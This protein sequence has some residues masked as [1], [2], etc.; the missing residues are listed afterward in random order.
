MF[1]LG[2]SNNR[3]EALN[4]D[5]VDSND[6]VADDID[7]EQDVVDD[8]NETEQLEFS[9]QKPRL[10][11]LE[12]AP[13]VRSLMATKQENLDKVKAKAEELESL[14]LA[15]L[16]GDLVRNGHIDKGIVEPDFLEV[17]QYSFASSTLLAA[18]YSTSISFIPNQSAFVR[19]H[20]ITNNTMLAHELMRGKGIRQGDP[21]SLYLFVL[22]M[23]VL[24][25]L[26]D[27]AAIN[28]LFKY[29]LKC[30]RVRLTHL[31]FADDLLIF[32]KGTTDS[33]AGVYC[34]L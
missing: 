1:V 3:F 21:P 34:V 31:M 27:V 4:V 7:A 23:D 14:K 9:P 2:G 22:A 11:S 25:K 13:F 33:V 28:T 5:L 10:A 19:G 17:F 32:S 26:L 29:H 12:V 24:S 8:D 20:S 15:L 18:F 16:R 30:L 6:V